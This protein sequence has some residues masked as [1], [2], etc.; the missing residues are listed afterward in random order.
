M[1]RVEEQATT[2]D[3]AVLMKV[4]GAPAPQ[5]SRLIDF[6]KAEVRPGFVPNTFILVVSGTA[7]AANMRVELM[8]VVYIR[9]PEYWEI[10]V[11]G[12]IPGPICLP[13][14]R[15]YTATIPLDGIIGTAGIEVVGATRRQRIRVP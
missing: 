11:V 4:R 7:P 14:T 5:S 9:R 1:Q 3:E 2:M 10:E 6:E 12:S 8:P 13:Q 15:P